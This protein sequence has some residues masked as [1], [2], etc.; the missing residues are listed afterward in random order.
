MEPFGN[1]FADE[2]RIFRKNEAN[3]IN[4][5]AWSYVDISNG[6]IDYSR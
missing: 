4:A 6:D 3:N 5:Y 2:T 1:A